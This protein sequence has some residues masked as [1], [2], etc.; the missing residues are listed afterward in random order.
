MPPTRRALLGGAGTALLGGAASTLCG[1]GARARPA[2]KPAGFGPVGPPAW[3]SDSLQAAAART[4]LTYGCEVPHYRLDMAAYRRAVARECGMLVCGTAMKM[5]V[6]LAQPGIE[7]FGPGDATLRFARANG[8]RM[9]G[10]TLVWHNALPDWVQP[11]LARSGP[12]QAEAFLRRWIGAAAGH[13]RGTIE[14]W[15]VVNEVLA[16]GDAVQRPDGLRETPWLAS[17]GPGYIDLAFRILHEVDPGAAGTWN[18]DAV[19]QDVPWM[20]ARR[21]RVLRRLEGMLARGVPIRRFGLQ[22]HLTSTLPIDQERLRRF[23]AEI[24]GLGL[25]IEITELDFDDRAFPS[26]IAARDRG[27]TDMARRYLDVV[28]AE[29]AVLNVV[30]WD[31]YDPDTWL[32]DHPNRKR[33]DGLPQRALP[34]DAGFARKPLWHAFHKAFRDAPDHGAHRDRLRRG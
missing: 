19:E 10:H 32:N 11:L 16:I 29:K 13:W 7:D 28:C 20:E 6:V 26:D 33:P 3:T 5:E 12:A 4:G 22:S 14:A 9:R 25:G 27:V 8:Q 15:D 18:E 1:P 30:T 17:L 24:G 23:L 2:A 34:L 21:T 31:I